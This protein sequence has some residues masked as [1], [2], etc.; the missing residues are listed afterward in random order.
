MRNTIADILSPWKAKPTWRWSS[1]WARVELAGK[2]PR[3]STPVLETRTRRHVLSLRPQRT[4]CGHHFVL[5]LPRLRWFRCP[6]HSRGHNRDRNVQDC[7]EGKP[8]YGTSTIL[9]SDSSRLRSSAPHVVFLQKAEGWSR[10]SKSPLR[11]HCG[12]GTT[13]NCVVIP[14]GATTKVARPLNKGLHR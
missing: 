7:L 6:L 14:H 13:A 1:N 4:E 12:R 5:F 10:G 8:S 9:H 11:R 3:L 2:C